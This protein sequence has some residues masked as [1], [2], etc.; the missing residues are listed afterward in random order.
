LARTPLGHA[1]LPHNPAAN[2][3][4]NFEDHDLEKEIHAR[5]FGRL[6]LSQ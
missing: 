2:P 4:S 3:V 1:A 5:G 6:R